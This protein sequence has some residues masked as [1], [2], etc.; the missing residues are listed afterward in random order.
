MQDILLLP[1]QTIARHEAVL[2]G[3]L[4]DTSRLRAAAYRHQPDKLRVLGGALLTR[5]IARGRAAAY[6]PAGKPFI[7]GGPFLSLAHSGD[8]AVAAVSASAPV[9]IDIENTE[10]TRRNFDLLVQKAF[11]PDERARYR[12]SKTPACF[13]EIW[14]QKEAAFKM[15][16]DPAYNTLR[17]QAPGRCS[18]RSF[19]KR[20]PM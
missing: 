13:Y 8:Y 4:D 3:L 11:F 16:G 17:R 18:A 12:A 15:N 20:R 6:T 2:T 19:M 5:Y 9:G 1:I 10:N 14:T 7:P